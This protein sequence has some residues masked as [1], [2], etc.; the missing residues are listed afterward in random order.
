MRG[1]LVLNEFPILPPSD[2]LPVSEKPAITFSWE[3]DRK[4]YLIPQYYVIPHNCAA[5]TAGSG[6]PEAPGGVGQVITHETVPSFQC[7][8]DPRPGGFQVYSEFIL[9]Q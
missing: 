3:G 2:D 6:K 7:R 8:I 9:H 5:F 4:V 1:Y